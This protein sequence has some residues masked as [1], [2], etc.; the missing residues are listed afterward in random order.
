M[1]LHI[2]RLT[3]FI[4][5]LVH[6]T[7]DPANSFFRVFVQEWIPQVHI[8]IFNQ[9]APLV[10][11]SKAMAL[12]ESI[13]NDLVAP[14]LVAYRKKLQLLSVDQTFSAFDASSAWIF[15]AEKQWIHWGT[16]VLPVILKDVHMYYFL[17]K[18]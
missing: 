18:C 2:I 12:Q 14:I 3:L 17:L 5:E 8:K 13:K 15:A 6:A 9:I 1:K 16:N 10:P 11:P 7:S 4:L